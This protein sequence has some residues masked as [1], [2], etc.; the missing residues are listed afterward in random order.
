MGQKTPKETMKRVLIF[1]LFFTGCSGV[2]YLAVRTTSKLLY[3]ASNHL[4]LEGNWDK[5]RDGTPSNLVFFEGLLSLE[6]EN[7]ELLASLIKGHAAY[8]F[9]VYETLYLEDKYSGNSF[10]QNKKQALA[11]YSRAMEYGSRFLEINGITYQQV[12]QQKELEAVTTFLDQNLPASE[13]NVEALFFL[14]QALA[15]MISLQRERPIFLAQMPVVQGIFNWACGHRP[16]LHS[17]ACDIFN[18]TYM[19]QIPAAMGGKPKEAKARFL[20][21]MEKYPDNWL[22]QA[23][24]LTALVVPMQDKEAFNQVSHF[25]VEKGKRFEQEQLWQP[26]APAGPVDP[27]THRLRLYQSIALKRFEIIQK[28]SKE[29][30]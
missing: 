1:L 25:L 19:A 11:Y 12:M 8:A 27:E 14:A 23:N 7:R 15:G 4:E 24:Y 30:F 6:P 17:G 29:L 10:S 21:A 16:N 22:I 26:L 9:A 2:D 3:R 18:A 13:E 5:F 28:H 20:Q